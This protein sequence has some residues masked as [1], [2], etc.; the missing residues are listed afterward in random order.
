[1]QYQ[2]VIKIAPALC[3]VA[4]VFALGLRAG[5][6]TNSASSAAQVRRTIWSG[7]Y[8]EAQAERGAS[9]YL[10]NCS[11]CHGVDLD[12]VA[13]LKGNDFMERWREYDVRSLYDFISKSMPRQRRESPNRPGSLSEDLYVHINTH[14]F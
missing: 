14:N 10:S 7:V 1:M 4:L 8:T 5:P 6:Q 13:R 9:A 3:L 11:P 2:K 12:G